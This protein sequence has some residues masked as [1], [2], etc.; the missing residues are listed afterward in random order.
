MGRTGD[1]EHDGTRQLR[2]AARGHL[3]AELVA[4][5]QRGELRPGDVR[6]A[7]AQV[8]GGRAHA[9]ALDRGR[10]AGRPLE[11]GRPNSR[12][13]EST[14]AL[15]DAYLRLWFLEGQLIRP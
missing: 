3:V 1:D 15:R 6:A 5:R 8:G 9:V 7:A 14:P 2:Q 11:R 4:R 12:R 10:P 13:L